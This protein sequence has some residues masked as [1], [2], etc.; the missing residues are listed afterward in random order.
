MNPTLEE[1]LITI[2]NLPW[3]SVGKEYGVPF[4]DL[5]KALGGDICEIEHIKNQ[6]RTL[7]ANGKI[8]LYRMPP[9]NQNQ[10]VAARIRP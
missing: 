6:L 3:K 10:I 1:V 9:S 5:V 7:E 2:R 4:M 8:I